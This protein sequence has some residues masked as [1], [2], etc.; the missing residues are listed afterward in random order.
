MSLVQKVI[1]DHGME[2]RIYNRWEF[3]N[4]LIN[5][6]CFV[7]DNDVPTLLST[8]VDINLTGRPE[9]KSLLLLF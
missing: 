8:I 3:S 1:L 6:E 2:C 5:L 7:N 4:L 9:S